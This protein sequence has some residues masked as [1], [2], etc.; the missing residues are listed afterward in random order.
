MIEG[1]PEPVGQ[2]GLDA[3]HPG[4][5]VGHGLSGLGGGQ[6][7]GGAVFVRGA[8]EHDLMAP[9]PQIAGIEVG[10]QL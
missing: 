7:G 1:Q 8:D 2:R 10:G 3:M 5:I 6:F 9:R 4:A